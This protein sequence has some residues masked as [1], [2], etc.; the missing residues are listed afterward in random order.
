MLTLHTLLS[1]YPTP[2]LLSWLRRLMSADAGCWRFE[3]QVLKTSTGVLNLSTVVLNA[4]RDL[5]ALTA[6]QRLGAAWCVISMFFA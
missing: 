4:N 2:V 3:G 5:R 6:R 1:V